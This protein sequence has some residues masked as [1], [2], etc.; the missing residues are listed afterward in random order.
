VLLPRVEDG[1]RDNKLHVAWSDDGIN[2]TIDPEPIPLPPSDEHAPW[3]KHL[4]DPRITLLEGT[5]YITYC[6]Q[7]MGELFRIG[8]CSTKDFKTFKRYPYITQPWTRNC[9]IFPEKV[10]G[11]YARFDRTMMGEEVLNFV[12]YSPDL[13][14]WGN[15]KI[16]DLKTETW[17]RNKWGCGP[18][19]VK[20]DKGWLMIF[21]GVW[22]AIGPVYRIGMAL[23]DLEEPSRVVAQY[24]NFILTPREDYERIGEVNNCVFCNGLV[25]EDNG[26]I[27]LYYG[28]ADTCIGLAYGKLDE[29]VA[30]CMEYCV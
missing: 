6:A 30:A 16:I 25:V 14:H 27:K 28:A 17:L 20:T 7:T 13:V 10:N 21:H 29:L 22:Q 18:A 1:K 26:D 19:P 2:F 15:S 12:S 9:A 24:P 8:L 4:Y 11:L 23:L 3:E 5:Y